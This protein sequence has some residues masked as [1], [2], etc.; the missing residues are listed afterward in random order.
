MSPDFSCLIVTKANHIFYLS[1][2]KRRSRQL[3]VK[4]TRSLLSI[5]GRSIRAEN[6]SDFVFP[7]LKGKGKG[8]TFTWAMVYLL[9]VSNDETP[10]S[11]RPALGSH[12]VYLKSIRILLA[13]SARAALARAI[14]SRP[15]EPLPTW[16]IPVRLAGKQPVSGAARIMMA[17][18]CVCSLD[19]SLNYGSAFSQPY[20]G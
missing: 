7:S 9:L 17:P 15:H 19:R 1:S 6:E 11:L 20:L 8:K 5:G 18:H 4:H 10:V 13:L 3:R 12:K 16:P 2:A 14:L